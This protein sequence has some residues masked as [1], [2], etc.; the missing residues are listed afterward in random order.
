MAKNKIMVIGASP[1]PERYAYKA[2]NL[3]NKHGYTVI[4][5]GIR[6][7]KI[8]DI[9]ISTERAQFNDIHTITMYIGMQRQADYYGYILSLKPQRI[10][11]NPGTENPE[12]LELAQKNNINAVENC[13]LV[14]LN[15][16]MF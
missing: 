8:N 5:L 11:F 6:T 13:T 12:L 4:A 3:L 9:K 2:V 10:I 14:M 7:G 15:S 1:K 16:G